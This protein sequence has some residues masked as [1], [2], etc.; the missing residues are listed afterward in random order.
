MR[1]THHVTGIKFMKSKS[2]ILGFLPEMATTRES[3]QLPLG[4]T[5]QLNVKITESNKTM[6]RRCFG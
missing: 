3:V 2:L 4:V 5:F 1:L 6:G